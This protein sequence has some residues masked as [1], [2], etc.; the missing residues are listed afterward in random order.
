MTLEQTLG[1]IRHVLT[2]IGAILVMT[3]SQ[4]DDSQWQML[5]GGLLGLGAIVWSVISKAKENE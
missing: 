4:V 1:I 5:V 3:G 2:I